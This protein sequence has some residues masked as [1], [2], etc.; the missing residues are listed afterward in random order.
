MFLAKL[1]RVAMESI[2]DTLLVLFPPTPLP[3]SPTSSR[4]NKQVLETGTTTIQN[5]H[6]PP[7]RSKEQEPGLF[8]TMAY[9]LTGNY[10]VSPKSLSLPSPPSTPPRTYPSFVSQLEKNSY[11]LSLEQPIKSCFRRCKANKLFSLPTSP[12]PSIRPSSSS[13]SR[14]RVV[15]ADSIDD[16]GNNPRHPRLILPEEEF[17][18]EEQRLP[19]TRSRSSSRD[20]SSEPETSTLSI[21]K[22]RSTSSTN[23]SSSCPN[24]PSSVQKQRAV[25]YSSSPSH[26]PSRSY[27][28][29][30]PSTSS[31]P[32]ITPSRLRLPPLAGY[33][34]RQRV[35]AYT[36]YFA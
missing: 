33:E 3:L 15:F 1:A 35:V 11:A 19:S 10:S 20:C 7:Q 25:A 23:Q 21:P 34:R 32:R 22:R 30:T 9:S 16:G 24:L 29:I 26:Q 14:R 27:S 18:E 12:S 28:T 5:R 2:T 17:A 4:R 8:A 13:I 6:V 31:T 36:F